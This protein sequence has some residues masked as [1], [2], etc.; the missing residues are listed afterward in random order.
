MRVVLIA[1]NPHANVPSEGYDLYVHF[2]SAIHWGKTPDD[3]SV[4]IVRINQV[5][6]DKR[7]FF[8]TLDGNGNKVELTARNNQIIACGWREDCMKINATKPRVLCD[9]IEYPEKQSPTTGFAAMYHYLDCNYDVFLCGFDLASASYY[10]KTKLH[11]PDYEIKQI[12]LMIAE[13][14]VARHN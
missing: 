12:E 13:G 7:S 1:N 8:W 2:N 9:E 3:K 5:V 11:N 6:K 14:L 4:I 10:E